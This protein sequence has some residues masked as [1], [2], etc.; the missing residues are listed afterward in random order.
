MDL[1]CPFCI[2]LEE[3]TSPNWRQ[4]SP[5]TRAHETI[6]SWPECTLILDTGPVVQGHT[7]LVSN[8][9]YPSM[10]AVAENE[11]AGLE[12]ARMDTITLMREVFGEVTL[13]EHGAATFARNAGA[14]VDHAHIHFVPGRHD[15]TGRIERDFG[16][17]TSFSTWRGLT[18]F[19]LRVPYLAIQLSEHEIFGVTAPVCST[20]YLRRLIAEDAGSTELWNWRDSIRWKDKSRTLRDLTLASEKLENGDDTA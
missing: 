3:G 18:T 13:V 4:L 16:T 9:H 12:G 5:P 2:L 17:M 7:L 19:F 11:Q 6:H 14:C 1:D 8:E 10:A 15:I 20:Q